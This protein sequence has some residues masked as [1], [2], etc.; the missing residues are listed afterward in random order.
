VHWVN[1]SGTAMI[2]FRGNVFG[3]QTL[4]TFTPLPARTQRLFARHGLIFRPAW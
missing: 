2:A 3:V 4:T 1:K